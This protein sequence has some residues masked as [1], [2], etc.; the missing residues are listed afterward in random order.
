M[1]GNVQHCKYINY[2]PNEPLNSMQFQAKS[3]W[4]FSQNLT[5]WPYNLYGRVEQKEIATIILNKQK[6]I[7]KHIR[8]YIKTYIVKKKKVKHHA[9]WT[10][11]PVVHSG[12]IRNQITHRWI[13]GI[14][15][16]W[17]YKL[18]GEGCQ[19]GELFPSSSTHSPTH[20][21]LIYSILTC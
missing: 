8:L 18:V 16:K 21:S 5:R 1:Y 9:G 10:N 12:K 13:L 2:P 19:R 4:C 11:R 3:P 20:Y 7:R 6:N 17:H 14:S 15:Q